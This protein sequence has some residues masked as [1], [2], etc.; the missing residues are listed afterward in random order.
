MAAAAGLAITLVPVIMGYFI[1]GKVLAEQANPL[2][3]WLSQ[4][5]CA[6]AESRPGPPENHPGHRRRGDGG[7]LLAAQVPGL[8]VHTAAR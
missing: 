3:R 6:T 7:G 8:R 4:G 5:I 1:R 2:N